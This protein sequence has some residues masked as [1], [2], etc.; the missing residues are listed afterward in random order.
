MVGQEKHGGTGKCQQCAHIR[1]DKDT[2]ILACSFK[3]V[4]RVYV[5]LSKAFMYLYFF[6]PF[7]PK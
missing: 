1:T 3:E 2:T 7:N 5:F 4:S 6:L